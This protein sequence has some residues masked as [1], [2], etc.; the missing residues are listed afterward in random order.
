MKR[1]IKRKEYM[2]NFEEG[3]W[4]T[5]WAKTKRQAIKLAKSEWL[6]TGSKLVVDETSFRVTNFEAVQQACKSFY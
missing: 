3:G 1:E 2:Y 4:N 6:G 5:V